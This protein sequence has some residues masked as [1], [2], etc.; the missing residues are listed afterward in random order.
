MAGRKASRA[1]RTLASDDGDPKTKGR[2][3]YVSNSIY[4]QQHAI[5]EIMGLD[6]NGTFHSVEYSV[7]LKVL[8]KRNKEKLCSVRDQ[9]AKIFIFYDESIKELLIQSYT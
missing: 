1:I 7:Q 4:G 2:F 9:T 3:Y 5:P 8:R 6:W